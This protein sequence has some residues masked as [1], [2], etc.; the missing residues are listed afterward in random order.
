MK[1]NFTVMLRLPGDVTSHG[2]NLR[3]ANGK[4]AVSGLPGKISEATLF[5]PY[6]GNPFDF[7]DH[8]GCLARTREG[9]K[10]VNMVFRAA[11]NNRLAIQIGQ[12][13][14]KVMVQFITQLA[15]AKKWLAVFGGKDRMDKDFPER[16]RHAGMMRQPAF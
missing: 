2:F 10:N 6:R 1:R 14:A 9:G 3:N 8:G 12:D 5:E 7:F 11:G 13:A 16:L 15:V 4:N